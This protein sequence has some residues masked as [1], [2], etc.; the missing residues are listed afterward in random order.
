MHLRWNRRGEKYL[1]NYVYKEILPEI[2]SKYDPLRPYW[3]SSPYGNEDDPNA[4]TEGNRHM[5]EVWSRWM[6][7]KHYLT[8]TGRFLSEFG[9]QAMPCWRTVLDFTEPED[10]HLLSPVM[11]AH[12]KHVEGTEKLIRFMTG[13]IGFPK[14]LKSFVYLS[15]FVQAEAIKTGVEHWRSRKF[16]T[17]GTLYWQLNDSWPVASWASIDYH[18]RKKGLYYYTKK[19]YSNVLP[20]MKYEEGKITLYIIN[21]CFE[22][23]HVKVSL[24]AY[25]LNGKRKGVM[26]FDVLAAQ[27]S[28][29]KVKT[30]TPEE[31]GIGQS[32]L[33][34]PID[35]STTTYPVEKNGDLLDTVVFA[36]IEVNG[37]R[38]AN[39]MVFD[40]FRN[41]YLTPPHIKVTVKDD[42]I[43][44]L[45]D[46]PAFGVF[47]E[48]WNEVELSDNCLNLEPENLYVI[49][50]SGEP[51]KVQ[52]ED[53]TGMT[54]R[55]Y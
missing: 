46:T 43:E 26:K 42:S 3:V 2:C 17:A 37:E 38:I 32:C 7:Y 31:L 8:D 48:T 49:H 6:D 33:I 4:M 22:E 47:I 23:L 9:F 18:R 40:V 21:D 41:L 13:R 10:R 30:I 36:S 29:V 1:G 53:L 52:V 50:T 19:F 51:G 54:A 12:N 11:L 45:S 24:N 25:S 5:W 16:K 28:S 34:Q 27:N 35:Y 14:D 44:L 15:Q 39:Y 55:L 20:I